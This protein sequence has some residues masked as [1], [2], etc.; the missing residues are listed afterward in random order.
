MVKWPLR[1]GGMPRSGVRL[2]LVV[3][4]PCYKEE[5]TLAETLAAIPRRLEGIDTI[6]TLV[7]D[8]G[9]PDR[10]SEVA[11]QAGADHIVRNQVNQGLARAFSIGLDYALKHGADIIVNTDADNQYSADC[12]QALIEPVLGGRADIVVGNRNP[13]RLE[14]FS[15][16]KRVLQRFGSWVV[17]RLSGTEIPD[18]AS[19]F[20][21]FSREAAMRM[22]IVSDFTYTL[23][24]II[25][26]G[27]KQLSITHVDVD[28]NPQ[29]R[30]SRLF[31][32]P[33]SYVMH[34]ISTIIRIYALYE[35]LRVFSVIGSILLTVGAA[36]G[37]RFS[38][39]YMTT[40][41][42][43]HVQ[44]LILAAVLILGGF[45][46][47]LTGLLADLVGASRRMLEDAMLRIRR[48]ELKDLE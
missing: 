13:S 35:P 23:E 20:R 21:A 16:A 26:A 48:I 42:E 37:I 9:S 29:S 10:T 7:I 33:L 8:D 3:Q 15:L 24:T 47:I 5:D 12:I 18:A 14:H 6:E 44:S 25:Q 36:I 38:I 39:Y 40:G 34:S 27:K 2:K 30:P 45:Q 43:G 11:V 22:N 31:A 1:G 46:T 4:I 28:V 32:S 41:G 19:G 17:R